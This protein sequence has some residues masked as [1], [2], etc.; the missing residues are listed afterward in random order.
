MLNKIFSDRHILDL[1][2]LREEDREKRAAFLAGLPG[3][4]FP[5]LQA[6]EA[7]LLEEKGEIPLT[8]RIPKAPLSRS[9]IRPSKPGIM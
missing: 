1:E 4:D 6:F 7:S 5:S 9:W 8:E 2:F 3:L